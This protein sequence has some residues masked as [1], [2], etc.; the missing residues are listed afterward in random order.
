MSEVLG[1]LNYGVGGNPA[2][3]AYDECVEAFVFKLCDCTLNVLFFI[4]VCNGVNGYEVESF[5]GKS[6]GCCFA[7]SYDYFRGG[8]DFSKANECNFNIFS[9]C[10]F[11][12]LGYILTSKR[13]AL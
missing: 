13:R 4:I 5:S 12:M 9:F 10:L 11:T 2:C 3:D 1:N 7:L 6:L 8:V